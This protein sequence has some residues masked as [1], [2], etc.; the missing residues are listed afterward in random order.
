MFQFK[1]WSQGAR[2][3]AQL[4]GARDAV[5]ERGLTIVYLSEVTESA[6]IP[7]RSMPECWLR[8]PF[9]RKGLPLLCKKKIT[10]GDLVTKLKASPTFQGSLQDLV[11]RNDK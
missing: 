5:T 3:V 9:N 6:P 4:S 8:W 2:G 7:S 11:D 10:F 1:G